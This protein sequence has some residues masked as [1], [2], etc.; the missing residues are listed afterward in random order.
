MNK[1]VIMI[2]MIVTIY[3]LNIYKQNEAKNKKQKCK[4]VIKKEII[5]SVKP[6]L[7]KSQNTLLQ[8]IN[9]INNI[10]DKV[11]LKDIKVRWSLQRD[12]IDYDLN[13]KLLSMIR[14]ILQR[15]NIPQHHYFIK[16]VCL[17]YRSRKTI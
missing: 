1:Y 13:Q 5:P 14:H 3:M 11:T 8:N 10:S 12:L 15:I 9:D 7:D 2:V 6:S 16:T 4:N 17:R